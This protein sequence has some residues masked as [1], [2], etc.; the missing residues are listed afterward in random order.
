MAK[1]FPLGRLHRTGIDWQTLEHYFL[2]SVLLLAALSYWL[3][4]VEHNA[5]ALRLTG[6]DMGELVK[7]LPSS[8]EASGS[9]PRGQVPRQLFYTPPF[10]CAICLLLLAA[11]KHLVYPRWLCVAVLACAALLLLGLLPP[12]WAAGLGGHAAP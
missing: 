1:S 4:W 12:V 6:Q 3:P 9:M 2:L 8:L 11:N 5:A 10:A 7:F